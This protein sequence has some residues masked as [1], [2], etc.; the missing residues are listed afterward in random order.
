MRNLVPPQ[1]VPLD[2]QQFA[3]ENVKKALAIGASKLNINIPFEGVKFFKKS[4][5]ADM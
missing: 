3:E 2:L 5:T 1:L 4:R